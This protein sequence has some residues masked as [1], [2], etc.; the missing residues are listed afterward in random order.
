MLNAV[1]SEFNEERPSYG[2]AKKDWP[3]QGT[4]SGMFLISFPTFGGSGVSRGVLTPSSTVHLG[5][6]LTVVTMTS[7]GYS[8]DRSHT[9]RIIH[10][11]TY[12][13]RSCPCHANGD[14]VVR[15]CAHLGCGNLVNVPDISEITSLFCKRSSRGIGDERASEHSGVSACLCG[16]SVT[17][18]LLSVLPWSTTGWY[19][20]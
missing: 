11:H 1:V 6:A 16:V 18:M 14:A 8:V 9:V 20:D 19:D 12:T 5:Q 15:D 17:S 13:F 7:Y 2:R 4:E 10:A 3:G